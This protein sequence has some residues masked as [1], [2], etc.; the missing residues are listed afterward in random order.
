MSGFSR[1]QLLHAAMHWKDVMISELWYIAVDYA[2]YSYDYLPNEK[3]I[4]SAELFTGVTSPRHKLKDC[5]I[6]GASVYVLDLRL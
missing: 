1:A 2:L 3:G 6:W 4:A 5:H